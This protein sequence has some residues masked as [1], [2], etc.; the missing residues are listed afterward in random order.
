MNDLERLKVLLEREYV[1]AKQR[2]YNGDRP[3]G[4]MNGIQRA[5]D[6]IDGLLPKDKEPDIQITVTDTSGKEVHYAGTRI[7]QVYGQ[8]K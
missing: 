1:L 4:F 8:N 7:K 6:H 5:M 3:S 2:Q